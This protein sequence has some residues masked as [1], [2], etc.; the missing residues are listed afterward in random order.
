MQAEDKLGLFKEPQGGWVAEPKWAWQLR[1]VGDEAYGKVS[2]AL[3][4]K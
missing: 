2:R 4:W 1:E 3:F